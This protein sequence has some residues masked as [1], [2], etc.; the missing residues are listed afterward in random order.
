MCNTSRKRFSSAVF[1]TLFSF[2]I[3]ARPKLTS[4]LQ[5]V[6]DGAVRFN[7]VSIITTVTSSFQMQFYLYYSSSTLLT[8]IYSWYYLLHKS[9]NVHVP[10]ILNNFSA[11]L[12]WA[13]RWSSMW[14]PDCTWSWRIV[15]PPKIPDTHITMTCT[16]GQEWGSATIFTCSS[17]YHMQ[18]K[19]YEGKYLSTA[20]ISQL[21]QKMYQ[22]L[23]QRTKSPSVSRSGEW[24]LLLAIE[25]GRVSY[26]SI[27]YCTAV[28][29]GHAKDND[30]HNV[31][32]FTV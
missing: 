1:T 25:R 7:H 19:L 4:H 2:P 6:S 8:L 29:R 28:V 23:F 17:E 18:T 27:V 14:A 3:P 31:W 21:W 11:G 20:N 22:A 13:P 26:Y 24:R 12:G 15:S 5:V 9:W 32:L 10:L 16:H 30:I